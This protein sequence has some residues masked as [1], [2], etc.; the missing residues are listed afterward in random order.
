[1][2]IQPRAGGRHKLLSWCGALGRDV[3]SAVK[4]QKRAT[5]SAWVGQ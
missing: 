1:M 2:S 5:K 4:K 3:Q